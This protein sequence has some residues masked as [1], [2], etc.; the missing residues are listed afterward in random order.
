MNAIFAVTARLR[1]Q[2]RV[3]LDSSDELDLQLVITYKSQIFSHDTQ[4][5]ALFVGLAERLCLITF[6]R[7]CYV[8]GCTQ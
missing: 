6:A 1:I 2:I 8:T 4:P 3:K 7:D 5:M